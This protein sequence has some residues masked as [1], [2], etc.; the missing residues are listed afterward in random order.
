MNIKILFSTCCMPR[1]LQPRLGYR[2]ICTHQDTCG[3][4]LLRMMGSR[5]C[6][7]SDSDSDSDLTMFGCSS[8]AM[9]DISLSKFLTRFVH[10][11]SE[12]YSSTS[13]T[14]KNW[15]VS[16][17]KPS[18]TRPNAPIYTHICMCVC[19]HVCLY[20]C[21]LCMYVCMHVCICLRSSPLPHV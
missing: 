17:F 11:L 12:P 21:I 10:S 19:M 20:V 8:L 15:P 7:Y 6:T 14:A 16:S 5:M 4:D 13:L 18:T 2:R 9:M 3:G 1:Y